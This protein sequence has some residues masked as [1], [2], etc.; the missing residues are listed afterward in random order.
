MCPLFQGII[1]FEK[2]GSLN[3]VVLLF[4]SDNS[5]SFV[6]L[7]TDQYI[8]KKKSMNLVQVL[9]YRKHNLLCT[10][11]ISKGFLLKYQKDSR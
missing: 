10:E 4:L 11:F 1:Y 7:V 2:L 3:K 5:Q 9:F 6:P 8:C